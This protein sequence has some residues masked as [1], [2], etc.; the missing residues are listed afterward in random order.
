MTTSVGIRGL[1]LYLPDEV[2]RND[3]WPPDVTGAWMQRR[4]QRPAVPPEHE[5]TD[6]ARRILEAQARQAADPFQGTVERRIMPTGMSLLDMEERA[7][8]VAL[9]RAG[10]AVDQIDLLLTN[11]TVPDV[12]LGNPAC[13][14]HERLGLPAACLSMHTD[15]ATHAFMMQLELAEGMI[16]AGRARFAMLVQS[17]APSRLVD[18]KD[19]NAPFFGDAATA[20]IVGPVTH[21]RGLAASAHFTDGRFP[22]TLI[23]TVPG[24]RWYDAGRVLLHVGDP[25]QMQRVFLST[26]DACRTA[27][28]AA[29]AKSARDAM[30]VDFVGI[31]QGQP[32]LRQVVQEYAGLAHARSIDSFRE[33]GYLF[34]STIP[35]ALAL[36]ED[37][38]LLRPDDLV[39]LTGGGP[40]MTYGAAVMTWGV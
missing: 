39:V 36:A 31:H 29:L 33:T 28:E 7:A 2:R 9:D 24:A 4:P 16:L 13:A 14:L 12:L 26:A 32:W 17:C 11:Q 18:V 38:G 5:L 25:V 21:G 27:I 23:A 3:F 6:G 19:P 37:R 1:G 22:K 10:V 8:R 20:T 35:A 34:A 30:D 15:V 40:G